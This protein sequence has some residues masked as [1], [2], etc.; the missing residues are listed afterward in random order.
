[1]NTTQHK[2]HISSDSDIVSG[3]RKLKPEEISFEDEMLVIGNR[4]NF[5]IP[6]CF[7][8][9]EVFGEKPL[10]KNEDGYINVYANYDLDEGCV[11]DMLEIVKVVDGGP[12][13]E[14]YYP[15]SKEEKAAVMEKMKQYHYGKATLESIQ[16]E[17]LSEKASVLTQLADA[18]IKAEQ[19]PVLKGTYE[20][21]I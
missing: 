7:D 13:T 12:E 6:V 20:H 2:P 3:S 5:Y 11:C 4:L 17:Y 10:I 15:L 18:R 16:S 19:Q 1:M 14:Y 21:Q 9:A 8:V